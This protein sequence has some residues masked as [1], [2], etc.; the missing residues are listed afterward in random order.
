MAGELLHVD[1]I[2]TS[3]GG[4]HLFWNGFT[5]RQNNK[6]DT[7]VSWKCTQPNCRA[8]ICT[9]DDTPSKIGQPH[10][11][12]PNKAAVEGRRILST[13]RPRVKEELTPLPSIYD[14]EITRILHITSV[15]CATQT[16]STVTG[17]STQHHPCLTAYSPYT[18][19][20][21]SKVSTSL[22]TSVKERQAHIYQTL[23]TTQ[24]NIPAPQ[25]DL[26]TNFS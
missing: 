5:Y 25:L 17:H 2:E 20:W 4:R 24:R 16:E 14:E 8:T 1:F 6:R 18:P 22:H 15:I 3:G 9:R 13:I 23:H 10:T 21:I 19:C 12:L 26:L 11:H 7:W